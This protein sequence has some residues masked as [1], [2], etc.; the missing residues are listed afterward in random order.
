MERFFFKDLLVK[1]ETVYPKPYLPT[2]V[3]GNHDQPRSIERINGDL[4]KAKILALFQLTAR[5]VPVVY[6]GEEIGLR[7][8]DFSPRESTD[9]LAKDLDWAPKWLLKLLDVFVTRDDARTPMQWDSTSTSGF[10]SPQTKPWLPFTGEKEFRNVEYQK[11]NPNSIWNT[12]KTLIS[13]RKG[14]RSFTQED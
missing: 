1:N 10:T 4:E 5:G 3:F 13:L 11:K 8:G 2:Y 6:Y 9:P 12:Y 14:N 7:G